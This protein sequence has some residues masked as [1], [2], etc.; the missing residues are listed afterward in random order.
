VHVAHP[1]C[2]FR[3]TNAKQ[4]EAASVGACDTA[5]VLQVDSY[6]G[7]PLNRRGDR[8]AA[9][10]IM[11]AEGLYDALEL[12]NVD[13]GPLAIA[14][15]KTKLRGVRSIELYRCRCTSAIGDVLVDLLANT[16]SINSLVGLTVAPPVCNGAHPG[17]TVTDQ[18]LMALSEVGVH[19]RVLHVPDQPVTTV[20]PFATTLVELDA[21]GSHCGIGDAGLTSAHNIVKLVAASNRKITTAAPFAATLVELNA[22]GLYCGIGDAELTS[23]HNIVKLHAENNRKITTVAPFAATLVELDASGG[24]SGIGDQGLASARSIVKLDAFNNTGI[25]TVAPFAATLVELDASG[26]ECGIDDR[27][28]ASAHSIAKLDASHNPK[29]TTVA[30]FAATLV[31]LT[32]RGPD[33]RWISASI[34]CGLKDAGLARAHGIVKLDARNNPYITT[35]APF[36]AALMELN[37]SGRWCGIGDAGLAS[38]HNIVKLAASENENISAARQHSIG[39]KVSRATPLD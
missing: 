36:A 32:A 18:D 21:S 38:A 31:E 7:D 11:N 2:A 16:D 33:T 3:V 37:A 30:P 12:H 5:K 9:L 24:Y 19:L 1:E 34:D 27:G 14:A 28:L 15:L 20:A 39:A 23:A 8:E 6:S 10:R 17:L 4:A 26:S 13:I 29:I 35:V 25:T 22:S